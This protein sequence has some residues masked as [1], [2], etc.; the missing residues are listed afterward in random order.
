[1]Q[2]KP[3]FDTFSGGFGGGHAG[4]RM[5]HTHSFG[6]FGSHNGGGGAIGQR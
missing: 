1:M 6:G 3:L 4:G 5:F 2:T